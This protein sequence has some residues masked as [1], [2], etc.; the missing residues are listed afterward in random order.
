MLKRTVIVSMLAAGLLLLPSVGE[1]ALKSARKEAAQAADPAALCNPRPAPDDLE[2]PMPCGMKMVLRP[3]AIPVNGLLG[4]KSFNMGLSSTDE[5]RGFYEK[6]RTAHVSAPFRQE[7]LPASWVGRLPADEKDAYCYYFIGKYEITNAQWA[8]VM[9]GAAV[10]EK[11]DLPKSDI[12]WYDLQEFLRR[13]NEWLLS[14]HAGDVPAIDGVPGFFRLPTETEWEFAARGGNLPPEME[15]DNDFMLGDGKTVE[16]YAVFGSRYE[17][18]LPVGSRMANA[19]GIYDMAGNVAEL[20]QSGF[21]FTISDSLEGGGHIR[22]LHGAEGGLLAKGGSFLSGDEKD[23]YP[24]KR[25]EVRM[26]QKERDGRF[27]PY[28]TRSLGARVVLASINIPG[29]GRAE[30][31]SKALDR[32]FGSAASA[33]KAAEAPAAE[34]AQ[35]ASDAAPAADEAKS[36]AKPASRGDR[37]VTVKL[38]GDPLKELEKIYA[39][40]SSPFVKSNLDQ[41]RDLL[42]DVN[43]SLARERDANLLNSLRSAVYKADSLSNIAFRCYQLDFT[44]RD[45]KRKIPNLPADKERQMREQILEHY[46]NL[47]VSTNFYRLSVKEIA[48]YPRKDV[49]NKILQLRKEYVGDDRLNTNFRNNL[50]AF[51]EHVEFAR[52]QGTSRLTNKMVWNKIIPSKEMLSLL[53]KLGKEMNKKKGR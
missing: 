28:S 35:A 31:I 15:V 1:A 48:A 11:G 34:V 13:Y 6:R 38:D 37:L 22:R 19:L 16:D 7:N 50:A 24:G 12:S 29:M 17:N 5:N 8:A 4:D 25:V 36:A 21:R 39:A 18:P 41:F 43:A 52:S 49:E 46:K 26:F 33:E 14:E 45:V 42:K 27:Q 9:D 23:V 20:V 53:D 44:L 40:T 32:V 30:A 10:T 47:E 2:L 51:A 3:V